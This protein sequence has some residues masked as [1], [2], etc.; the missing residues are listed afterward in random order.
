[1]GTQGQAFFQASGDSDAYTG[2]QTLNASSGPIPVDSIYVTSVG[3]T[4][5]S[6]NTN[7]SPAVW[8]SEAVWNWNGTQPNVG[9]GGGVSTNY[10][11]PSWQ[12][13]VS[14]AL[15]G[16]STVYR[17]IPD[18]AM[19]AEAIYV[20][21]N[22]GS[23]SGL[24]GGTSAA[25]P[26]WAGFCALINQQSVTATG[27]PIGFLNPAIYHLAATANYANYFHDVTSGNNIGTGTAGL[28][29]AAAGYD[30]CT[31]LGSPNGINLINALVSPVYYTA[32]TNA[33]WTLLAESA[34]PPNGA[35]N[36]GETVAV[37]FTLQN[38]GTLATSNLVATL[39]PNAGVLAPG[40]PQVYGAVAA[41]GGA[42]NESFTFT[43]AGT[44]GSNIVAVLQLQDGTNNLGTVNFI[45]PL[46]GP[47][48]FQS[49]AQNFDNL[50]APALPSGWT[51]ANVAGTAAAW[52]TT[53]AA[54]D[55]SPNSAFLADAAN[56]GENALV[57]PV[58]PISSTSAQLSFR[59]NYSL[60]YSGNRNKTYYD[61]EVLEIQIGN[62]SFTDILTAGGSF[63]TGGYNNSITTSSDN[64]LGGRS[65][66][67]GSSSGWKTV[68]VNLPASTAGQNIQLR[69]NCATDTGNSGNS[70]VGWYVDSISITDATP[71]CLPVF[72]DIVASQSLATNSLNAG[73]N[74][75][76]TLTVT[77]LGPQ[78]AANVTVTDTVPANVTLVSAS[79]GY[80]FSAGQ[81][82]W[83]AGMLPV[84][85]A[86]NFTLTLS[87]AVGNVFT[88]VVSVGTVT[89]EVTTANN[90]TTL[91]STQAASIP[92]SISVGP[93]SQIIQCGGNAAFSVTATGTAPLQYQWSLDS[94]PVSGATNASFSVSSLHLPNHAV[95]VTV[96]NLYGSVTSN[97]VVTVIDTLPPVITL[98]GS[99]P[100]YVELG[101]TFTDPGATASDACAGVVPVT[102]S[103]SV[104]TG[105]VGTN[106]LTYTAADGNGNTNTA[107]RT[108]I[109]RDTTPPTI[110]WSFTNLTLAADTNCSGVMP[111]VTGTN[112][113]LATDLSG[114]L[115]VFQSP[116]NNFVLPLGTNVVV[117]A[118]ADASGN[119]AFST[120]TIVVQDETPPL[121]FSQPQNQTNLVGSAAGFSVSATA[122]TPLAY[123]WVFNN[124]VLTSET[125]SIL[126]LA[127][128]NLTN[129]GNYSVT[130]TAAGGSSNSAVATLTVF[131][132][133]PVISG[134]AAN[135]G[136][137]FTLNLAGAPGS[138]Y[139]LETT[140][141]LVPVI[142]WLPI[143]TNTLDAS[144]TWQFTD[145]QAVNFQQQFYR[146]EL[147][148]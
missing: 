9:S 80:S 72:T 30:L 54:Y 78:A 6:M 101:G 20:V 120:N 55:T 71:S 86:T 137:S 79:P 128:V 126:T 127:S 87:P 46:G 110:L 134:V 3:G 40:G 48:R 111:D 102:V 135:P 19:P 70:A 119:T 141:N 146:L 108:V 64:P 95:T 82:V 21:Y 133:A 84:A 99:N 42:T 33:G 2:S 140:T 90:T 23:S 5:L 118:V 35:I 47:S 10:L 98:N 132:P 56:P 28:Y 94:S 16:G 17:N 83:S 117:I 67:V 13:N 93:A 15:N 44:C 129:A 14:M 12:T 97:A 75:I 65:A 148:P 96:T 31:G 7:V 69:W 22:N 29:N 63:V 116:T 43:A 88:N 124:A 114:A 109:V 34:T 92:A 53:M 105:S 52:G 11:I 77:N 113:F 60:E 147:A 38:Q 107:T 121:I 123:Q 125:N 50:A 39:Q 24:V 41:Y 131:N 104:S 61:G 106:T 68:T 73:Q 91:V 142:I 49:F 59:H 62:G 8:S 74:L 143:A 115:T 139:V 27:T 26:L 138:T 4:S 58:L 18:V 1:M 81:V 136:G 89:P 45:L 76:Y 144:G 145:P 85:A 32:M 103:G 51:T 66:W 130:V 112:Y 122:C 100:F 36:P 25:A 37:S 57:S